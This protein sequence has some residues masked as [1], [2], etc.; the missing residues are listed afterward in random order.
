MKGDGMKT[1]QKI[2]LRIF[3]GTV[4]P[5]DQFLISTSVSCSSQH[6]RISRPY[7]M[8]FS[9][10]FTESPKT[11]IPPTAA[12]N[13]QTDLTTKEYAVVRRAGPRTE[14]IVMLNVCTNDSKDWEWYLSLALQTISDNFLQCSRLQSQRRIDPE[15][16]MFSRDRYSGLNGWS[17]VE[18]HSMESIESWQ[19]EYLGSVS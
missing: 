11:Q 2:K 17:G 8:T 7:K 4:L 14:P 6:Q 19:K 3:A 10:V 13:W 16:K 5:C 9:E 1:Y 12:S 18:R 15:I